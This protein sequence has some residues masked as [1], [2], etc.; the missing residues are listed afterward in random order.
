MARLV[1]FLTVAAASAAVLMALSTSRA[2]TAGTANRPQLIEF[3]GVIEPGR[4]FAVTPMPNEK[5]AAVFITMDQR[6]DKGQVLLGMTSSDLTMGQ[7]NLVEKRNHIKEYLLQRAYLEKQLALKKRFLARLGPLPQTGPSA[8][9]QSAG[10]AF[11]MIQYEDRRMELEAEIA[12]AEE[13][14][15]LVKQNQSV[16]EALGADLQRQSALLDEQINR[17]TIRAPFAGRVVHLSS[18]PFRTPPG[19]RLCEVWDLSFL[20]VRGIV[21]QHQIR[22]VVRGAKALV[23]VEFRDGAPI[24]AVV[25]SVE[26]TDQLRQPAGYAG[27]PVI[28]KMEVSDETLIPGMNAIVRILPE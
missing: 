5:V 17:M 2:A 28:L 27:F 20:L 16:M 19:A 22:N 7:V 3:Q 14:L 12:A 26:P 6:V 21:M 1:R 10:M 18:D 24:R 9:N 15:A 8:Q 13:K 4:R 25:E 11:S 23:D